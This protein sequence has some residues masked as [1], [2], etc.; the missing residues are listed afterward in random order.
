MKINLVLLAL[1]IS[2]VAFSYSGLFERPTELLGGTELN[3]AGCVCHTVVRDTSVKVWIEGPDTLMVGQTGIYHMYLAGGPAQAGGYNVAGRFGT[4]VLT[5]SF[6]FWDYRSPNELTQAFPLVFPSA[7]DTIYWEFGY[8]AS[9]S[10]AIDTLYSCGLSIVYDGI[11]DSLD[12]WNFGPKFPI[13]IVQGTIPVE[14]IS[15]SAELKNNS[16]EL[17][18][19]TASETNNKGFE[20][21]RIQKSEVNGQTWKNVSFIP[22]KGT[23]TEINHYSFRDKNLERGEYI[24]RLKQIDFDGSFT[25]SEEVEVNI[26]IPSEFALLQNYPN[27]FNPSTKI[28]YV[29]SSETRNLVTLKVYDALGNE[30][31][32]LV[33]EEKSPGEYEVEFS[34]GRNSG[35]D[36]TSGV[37][38]Y[39]LS[40]GNFT[41][42]RKMIL[43][44]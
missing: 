15:F 39:Q 40:A 7:S 29:I 24:Y 23:S 22:G 1:F 37:Y 43:L 26:N 44:K 28:K 6:S 2:F 25:F 34:V 4:M 10:S 20:V 33:N 12:R 11:P 38:L 32:T 5:D 3:G 13:T 42:T 9:D 36:I 16:V 14:L 41:E 19:I 31:A 8:T 18:W 21:Q 35:P 27:P 17:N 30:V